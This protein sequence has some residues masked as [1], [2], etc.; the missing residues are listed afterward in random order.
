MTVDELLTYGN[1]YLHKDQVR[2]LLS[3][4]L[5]YNPLEILNHLTENV[6]E[7][8]VQIYKQSID[9]LLTNKPIQYV[10]GNVN[11]YGNRFQVNESVLIPR[12]ETEELVEHTLHYI[13]TYFEGNHRVLDLGTGSGVIG[14]TLKKKRPNLD[15]TLVDISKE[16]LL[17]A[18]E[19]AKNLEV[20]VTIIQSDMFE[21]VEGTYQVIIS[22]P[23]YIKEDEEIDPLVKD[24]EPHL[25]LY[26]GRDGLDC[27]RK[28]LRDIKNHL[29]KKYLIAFEIGYQQQDDIVNLIQQTLPSAKIETKQ[30]LQGRNRMIFVLG[31][32]E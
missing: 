21:N 15:V 14:I 2:M 7:E 5:G 13:D 20:D 4:L 16:A 22:N 1:Q 10:L 9:A 6:E 25:A 27:Y 32:L 28:I 3:D 26:G 29:D 30:D 19:N 12:F 11:F 23:P 24:N 18:E 17:V 31:N 8:T